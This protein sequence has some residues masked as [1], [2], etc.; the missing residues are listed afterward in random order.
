MQEISKE[1][2]VACWFGHGRVQIE[3]LQR[4]H[5]HEQQ[6]QHQQRPCAVRAEFRIMVNF[7]RIYIAYEDCMRR[8]GSSPS[9]LQF[10]FA[11]LAGELTRIVEDINE[12]KYEHGSSSCFAITHP[13]AR[14][15]YAAQFRDRVVQHFFCREIKP[16]LE[17]TFIDTTCSCRKKKGTDYA[18]RKLRE[19]VMEESDGGRRDCFY[20]KIDMSGYFMSIRRER[21]TRLMTELIE[22]KY[23]GDYKEE[24]LYLAPIIYMNNPAKSRI[25]K[26]SWEMWNLIPERKRM[27]PNG[28]TGLAIGNITAQDGSNL[29]L[30]GFDHYFIDD[31]GLDKYVR[32][33]DDAIAL[34]RDE[35]RLR[36]AL[37]LAEAKLAESGQKLNL[38]KTKIDTAYHGIK[39]LGK[40]TYP[41]GYQKMTKESAGRMMKAAHEFKM[42]ENYLS[43]LNAQAGRTKHYA[44]YG[45]MMDYIEALPPEVKEKVYFDQDKWKFVRIK[46][47]P[48][49]VR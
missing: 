20:L 15:I 30:D 18:L 22:K 6:E 34:N 28:E 33:V 36:D 7:E 38:R 14:E 45:L 46:E 39:F 21:V 29:N 26:T 1:A 13:T 25:M 48:N 23:R 40:M 35:K 10:S 41:Y 16:L 11:L 8:K 37:L 12:R 4:Q 32:Y 49:D 19:F 5:E 31:L 3:L 24:L 2:T 27:D 44:C 42:D 43:K 17:E 9:A 47:G